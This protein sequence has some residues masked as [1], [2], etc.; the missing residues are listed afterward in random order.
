[1][2][3]TVSDSVSDGVVDRFSNFDYDGF[4]TNDDNLRYH[5]NYQNR[6]LTMTPMTTVQ[7]QMMM[8]MMMI[9][10]IIFMIV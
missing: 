3:Q 5:H 7:T 8:I 6:N 10:G 1:M 9:I 4:G 2:T